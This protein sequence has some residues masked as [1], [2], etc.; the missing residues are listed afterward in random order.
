MKK[1]SK[2]SPFVLANS[3]KISD[4]LKQTYN[5]NKKYEINVLKFGFLE[6]YKLP[7]LFKL[8]NYGV[9]PKRLIKRKLYTEIEEI[10]NKRFKDEM[11]FIRK[12]LN[13]FA[14]DEEKKEPLIFYKYVYNY[15]LI[16]SKKNVKLAET[17]C[18]NLLASVD[19]YYEKE[20]HFRLF[21]NFINNNYNSLDLNCFLLLRFIVLKDM[22]LKNKK[23]N[24]KKPTFFLHNYQFGPKKCKKFLK[25]MF[26][27]C[28]FIDPCEMTNLIFSLDSTITKFKKINSYF[29]LC[30]VVERY[31]RIREIRQKDQSIENRSSSSSEVNSKENNSF[32][33]TKQIQNPKN[34]LQS[35]NSS[36]SKSEKSEISEKDLT[37]ELDSFIKNEEKINSENLHSKLNI[38]DL[39]REEMKKLVDKFV[40]SLLEEDFSEKKNKK[41]LIDIKTLI[42]VKLNKLITALCKDNKNDWF[43]EMLIENPEKNQ[44][45]CADDIFDRFK[46]IVV[47]CIYDQKELREFCKSIFKTP[48]VNN[49][50]S[51]LLT[52]IFDSN[53]NEGESFEESLVREG[54][55]SEKGGF[56]QSDM[57]N[58][59]FN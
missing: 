13:I 54:E 10:Y 58:L 4:E 15:F 38:P 42:L 39:I 56:Q 52:Y 22:N 18:L 53:N 3:F 5:T 35:E 37:N 46:Y 30:F 34:S 14:E 44:I 40:D 45:N 59:F 47:N 48:E 33:N 55:E 41:S 29:F 57:K 6:K 16:K 19:I 20:N 49:Q 31:K 27:E 21:F 50:I 17:K 11:T 32:T 25:E 1:T 7:S 51:C 28:E 26:K 24:L 9:R 12:T 43:L 8:Y 36:P 2:K 23:M